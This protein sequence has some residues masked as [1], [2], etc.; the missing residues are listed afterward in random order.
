MVKGFMKIFQESF[1]IKGFAYFLA[2]FIG[3]LKNTKK[4]NKHIFSKLDSSAVYRH[5]QT[6]CTR[7]RKN[8][9][10]FFKN[11]S[12]NI[13]WSCYVFLHLLYEKHF[14]LVEAA[15]FSKDC[16]TEHSLLTQ[17]ESSPSLA[18]TGYSSRWIFSEMGTYKNLTC[19]PA[20][21]RTNN[22]EQG[23]N[24]C[25]QQKTLIAEDPRPATTEVEIWSVHH[26]VPLQILAPSDKIFLNS[27]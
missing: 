24:P 18:D 27:C 17:N 4:T 20:T 23:F 15:K 12:E 26:C 8:F 7:T 13:K 19:H 2:A 14:Q 25:F 3:N 21:S 22:P 9:F 11:N 16:I 5:C 1:M 6:K 10:T